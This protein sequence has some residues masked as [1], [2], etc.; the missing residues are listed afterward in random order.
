LLGVEDE[1]YS[2]RLSG[3][4]ATLTAWTVAGLLHGLDTFASLFAEHSP[5]L[6]K[7]SA[8][9]TASAS[10][11]KLLGTAKGKEVMGSQAQ[12]GRGLAGGEAGVQAGE[13]RG[14][15]LVLPGLVLT[16]QP[17]LAWRGLLVDTA[18]HFLPVPLLVHTLDGM[19]AAKLNVLHLHLTDSQSFPLVLG[20]RFIHSPSEIAP[21]LFPPG[22]EKEKKY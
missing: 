21:H 19:K 22:L 9:A 3:A 18:R 4:K 1:A 8:A 12:G 20:D 10:A 2:L 17:A 5:V 6:R 7:P 13:V 15:E 16:D 14:A 11:S